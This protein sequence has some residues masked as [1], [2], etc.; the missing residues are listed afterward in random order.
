MG[1]RGRKGAV[2]REV[3]ELVA[4]RRSPKLGSP[5]PKLTVLER[6]APSHLREN[7]AGF[8]VSM[9]Q[10]YEISGPAATEILTRAPE[11]VDR[12]AAAR[13]TIAK[14]GELIENQYGIAKMNPA[15]A[16]EKAA[17]DGFFSAMRLLGINMTAN[18]T[19]DPPWMIPTRS[20]R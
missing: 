20:S 13:A 7:G 15:C 16:L 1:A 2:T 14:D 18:A 3:D 11:C 6:K 10:A 17:R 4:A 8:F 19:M 12:I 5:S 9:C